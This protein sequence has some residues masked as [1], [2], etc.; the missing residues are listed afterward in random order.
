MKKIYL[1]IGSPK[2]ATTAIQDC[3]AR[4]ANFLCKNFGIFYPQ[5]GRNVNAHHPLAADLRTLFNKDKIPDHCY[6]NNKRGKNWDNLLCEIEKKGRGSQKIILSSEDFFVL[7][8][9]GNLASLKYIQQKL[10]SYRVIIIVYLRR[11]DLFI[12]SL[13]N[14]AIKATIQH[15]IKPSR[16]INS[17]PVTRQNYFNI[18]SAWSQVFGKQNVIIRPFERKKFLGDDIIKDFFSQIDCHKVVLPYQPEFKNER[19]SSA[20]LIFKNSLN[21]HFG[22]NL[23]CINLFEKIRQKCPHSD[24]NNFLFLTEA[25]YEK[26]ISESEPINKMIEDIFFS[27]GKFFSKF[28]RKDEMNFYD[29]RNINIEEYINKLIDNMKSLHI[30]KEENNKIA[31][32]LLEICDIYSSKKYISSKIKKL[33]VSDN[34][35][36]LDILKKYFFPRKN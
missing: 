4:N 13:F 22:D 34:L 16:I 20:E 26:I 3:L 10:K 32:A 8:R 24:K 18:V 25:D 15:D 14:Q 9:T 5:S 36:L 35:S 27:G 19:L 17:H 7:Y 31:S 21:K 29:K 2:T 12:D 6:G 33:I 23:S 30:T 28:P 11:Q 1:H